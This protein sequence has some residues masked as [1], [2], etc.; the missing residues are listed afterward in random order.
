MKPI[1]ASNLNFMPK[2]RDPD[3]FKTDIAS[4]RSIGSRLLDSLSV[5]KREPKRE[6]SPV[7]ETEYNEPTIDDREG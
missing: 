5:G 4:I 3:E 7:L 6:L 2:T 1:P